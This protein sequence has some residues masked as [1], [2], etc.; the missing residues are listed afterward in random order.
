MKTLLIV[1]DVPANLSVL[2]DT[3]GA[4]DFRVLLADSGERA[5]VLV[6]KKRPDL[7]LL[8]VC[9]PEMDGVDVCRRL[10]TDPALTAVPVIFITALDEVVD[11]VAGLAA[12][13]VDY[14][15]KPLEPVEVLARVKVHLELR[16]LQV[17]LEE[18]N[19]ELESARRALG[20]SLDRAVLVATLDGRILFATERAT[21]LLA[22]HF[23]LAEST[24]LPAELLTAKAEVATS[25]GRLRLRRFAET[26][27]AE[28]VTLW[29]EEVQA[30]GG[31]PLESL[32]LTPREAEVLYWI[33]EGKSN[34]EIA[35]ILG[36]MLGTVKK[37]VQRILE[38]LGCESRLAAALQAKEVLD[39]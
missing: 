26:G 9:M 3:L 36:N 23:G 2:I 31:A 1:D 20:Q 17:K 27:E 28:C 14:I 13:A 7:I 38:K 8:D 5:L 30:S 11:K 35:L 19:R 25:A 12:G 32:G 4:A 33:A 10:K 24:E 22:A 34:P 39:R 16:D 15:T 21:R 18:R 6:Q 29:L 37:Q